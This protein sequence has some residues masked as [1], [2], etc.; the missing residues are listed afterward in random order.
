MFRS[1]TGGRRS[2]VYILESKKGGYQPMSFR[3]KNMKR[4]REKGRKRRRK[5]K[6]GERKG[7]KGKKN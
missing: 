1:C 3:G 2:G 5:R 4:P 6:K 7:R